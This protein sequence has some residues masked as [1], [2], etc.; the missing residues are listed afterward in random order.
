MRFDSLL[1]NDGDMGREDEVTMPEQD[2]LLATPD[3]CEGKT[4]YDNGIE[5]VEIDPEENRQDAESRVF[6]E[7]AEKQ[8]ARYERNFRARRIREL[9]RTPVGLSKKRGR[10]SVNRA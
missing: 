10:P 3:S 1:P 9:T 8:F 5:S 2:A 7:E 4:E 6:W